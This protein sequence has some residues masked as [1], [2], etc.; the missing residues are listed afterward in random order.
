MIVQFITILSVQ[1]YLCIS[2]SKYN[3]SKKNDT[4][5]HFP[6]LNLIE[7]TIYKKNI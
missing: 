7:H 4:V 3:A 5:A 2:V 6:T 1:T